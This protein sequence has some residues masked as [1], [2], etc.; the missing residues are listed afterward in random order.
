VENS[1]KKLITKEDFEN[2]LFFIINGKISEIKMLLDTNSKNFS[3]FAVDD[4]KELSWLLNIMIN[5]N[6]FYKT[7]KSNLLKKVLIQNSKNSFK[8]NNKQIIKNNYDKKQLYL[9]VNKFD[10]S[11]LLNKKISFNLNSQNFNFWSVIPYWW[12]P[13]L[14]LKNTNIMH[15]SFKKSK[16]VNSLT[17]L[18]KQSSKYYY[19][20][21]NYN[22]NSNNFLI[23]NNYI[24][25]DGDKFINLNKVSNYNFINKVFESEINWNNILI[26]EYYI[27]ISN[28]IFNLTVNCFNLLELNSEFVDYLIY[29]ILCNERFY[30]F[31]LNKLSSKYYYFRDN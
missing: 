7:L 5:K 17:L 27:L 9:L 6:D 1:I 18:L 10:K 26:I 2:Y 11:F 4:L 16:K 29:Y 14:K 25:D 21:N 31:E 13:N 8:K 24:T 23:N 30:D 22:N 20:S 28:L 19:F 15:W 12:E 3:N